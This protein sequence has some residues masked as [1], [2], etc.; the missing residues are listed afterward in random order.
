MSYRRPLYIVESDG[1]HCPHCN[2]TLSKSSF[3]AHKAKYFKN[4]SWDHKQSGTYQGK[5]SNVKLYLLNSGILKLDYC[6]AK[7]LTI[8]AVQLRSQPV[9]FK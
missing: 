2:E 3:Y 7:M 8:Y 4:G 5:P 9:P 6:A 1:K